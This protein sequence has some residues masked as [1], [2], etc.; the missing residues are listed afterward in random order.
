MI[1][2]VGSTFIFFN[3]DGGLKYYVTVIDHQSLSTLAVSEP[4]GGIK[5]G[6]Y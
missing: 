4:G 6:I 5:P 1:K 3:N 2:A